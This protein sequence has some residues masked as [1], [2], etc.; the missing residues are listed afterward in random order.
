MMKMMGWQMMNQSLLEIFQGIQNIHVYIYENDIFQDFVLNKNDGKRNKALTREKHPECVAQSHKLAALIKNRKLSFSPNQIILVAET[1]LNFFSLKAMFR[2]F[3]WLVLK[4]HFNNYI[5][6]KHL[7]IS[8]DKGFFTKN[9][10]YDISRKE[11]DLDCS[12]AVLELFI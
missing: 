4:G 8:R 5:Y 11:Q 10:V 9:L 6:L 1:S 3:K 2:E 7:E 12:C